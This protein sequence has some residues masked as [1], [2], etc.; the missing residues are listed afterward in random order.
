MTRFRILGKHLTRDEI[1]ELELLVHEVSG[2]EDETIVVNSIDDPDPEFDNEVVI[3]LGTPATCSSSDLDADLMKVANGA[4]R[5][6]WVWPEGTQT[7]D[8]PIPVRN[9]CY[10]IVP[11]DSG[12]LRTVVADD[13]VLR[14]ETPAGIP[15]PKVPTE[16]N[17]VR[18]KAIT[19]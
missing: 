7:V 1:E 17:C 18:D 4:R 12:K 6:I 14:F 8:L 16:R 13:D 5:A 9:Y 2:A 15:L 10:S 3:I 11:W 19:K